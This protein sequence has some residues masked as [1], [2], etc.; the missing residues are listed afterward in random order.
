MLDID[1]KIIRY[2][3]NFSRQSVPFFYIGSDVL[4]MNWKGCNKAQHDEICNAGRKVL[5]ACVERHPCLFMK[6]GETFKLNRSALVDMYIKSQSDS[7]ITDPR[8]EFRGLTYYA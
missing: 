1:E 4:G 3:A 7:Q 6:S 8:E 5:L 2:M